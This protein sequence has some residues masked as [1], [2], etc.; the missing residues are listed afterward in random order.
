MGYPL[1]CAGLA[2]LPCRHARRDLARDEEK[3]A[4]W[5][6]HGV[7]EERNDADRYLVSDC[8]IVQSDSCFFNLKTQSRR[9]VRGSLL[10]I[11]GT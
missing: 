7:R 8:A 3:V 9:N 1:V 5:A 11:F 6:S 2:L 10:P 4:G